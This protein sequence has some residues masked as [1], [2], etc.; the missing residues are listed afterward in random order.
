MRPRLFPVGRGGS[1]VSGGPSA[2]QHGAGLQGHGLA[3]QVAWAGP[4]FRQAERTCSQEAGVL[5]P[6]DGHPQGVCEARRA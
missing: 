6:E 3:A 1:G 4:R 2:A 5:T